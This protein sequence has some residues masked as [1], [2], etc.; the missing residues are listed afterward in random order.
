[1]TGQERMDRIE[2]PE[3]LDQVILDAVGLGWKKR[4]RMVWKRMGM[5]CAGMAAAF[6]VAVLAGFASPVAAKAFEGIPAVGKVFTY[7]YDLAGYQGRY[8]QVAENASPA[9][10]AET[11]GDDGEP[12]HALESGQTN[13]GGQGTQGPLDRTQGQGTAGQQNAEAQQDAVTATDG[14]VTVTVKEYFCDGQSLY[15][16]MEIASADPFF[17]EGIAEN[18]EGFIQ[19]FAGDEML[20]YEGGAPVS[21]GDGS[22]LAEGVFLDGHTFLG[23]ARSEWRNV[24]EENVQLPEEL[25]YTASVKHVKIYTEA[26]VLDYRG[27]WMLA[28]DVL[29]GGE[30]MEILSVDI[31]G[32][33]GSSICEVRL[34]PYEVQVVAKSGNGATTLT[35]EEKMLV[36][37]DAGGNLLEWAGGSLNYREGDREVYAFARP[38]GL[39]GLELFILKEADW[40]DQWKGRLYDGTSTGP[41]MV[42][43]LKENCLAHAFVDCGNE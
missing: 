26:G 31:E 19:L 13:P 32:D 24:R 35:E 41:E 37:F 16:S 22:L 40:M 1:M 6:T 11:L 25:I 38:E 14:G 17:E 21:V 43:F 3:E 5:C 7:L 15:L 4:K 10:P 23:I 29:L 39:D 33:D 34:Q 36:A 30:E 20:T 12:A 9:V 2:L 18:T 27:E 42:E 8:A 28:M